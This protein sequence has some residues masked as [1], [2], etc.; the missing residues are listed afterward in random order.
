MSKS[1]RAKGAAGE[2]EVAQLFRDAGHTVL[3]LQRNRD[4]L[5]DLL[6]DGWLYL[7]VKRQERHQLR[8]WVKQVTASAPDGTVPAVAFRANHQPW[9]LWLPAL[10]FAERMHV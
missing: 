9:G 1:Q 5:A 3:Q 6:V 10:D 4:E 8:E 2:Q 7:D